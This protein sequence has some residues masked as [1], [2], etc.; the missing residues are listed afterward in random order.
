MKK[1]NVFMNI[2][3]A[4]ALF[5]CGFAVFGW[6][7]A[8]HPKEVV[9]P[10][11]DPAPEVKL[12]VETLEELIEPCSKLITATDKY[13]N[14]DTLEKDTKTYFFGW[15]VPGST[16]II[17]Y[18]YIG[19]IQAGLNLADVDFDINDTS[20]TIYVMMPNP[21]VDD[22]VIDTASF[23]FQPKEKGI[24][25]NIEPD[26][27]VAKLNIDVMQMKDAASKSDRVLETAKKSAEDNLTAILKPTADSFGYSIKFATV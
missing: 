22:V 23:N 1:Q 2:I 11:V 20:K 10:G 5:G 17:E 16:E 13:T 4:A 24:F 19:T 14:K 25:T 26:E 15:H 12:T 3:T 21:T 8:N 27:F 18:S 6:V 7:S 9:A